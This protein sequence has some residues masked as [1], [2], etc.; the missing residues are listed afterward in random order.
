MIYR[1]HRGRRL[2]EIGVGCYGLSGA[3]GRKYPAE[4]QHLIQR[5]HEL[6][7]NYFDTAA[8][9]G[10]GERL[11]GTAVAPFRQQI[12]LTTKIDVGPEGQTSLSRRAVRQACARSLKRLQT[13]YLDLYLV[14]FDDP[15]TPVAETITAL[16]ELVQAGHIRH[17]GVSHL[18]QER[19]ADFLQSGNLLAVM[20]ELS[21][22]SYQSRDQ[23]LP[24]CRKHG[25]A[26]IAFSV[27]GR[28]LLTGRFQRTADFPAGDIRRLDPLFQRERLASG[29]RVAA[30]LATIG[31]Q[32][33]KTA[34]QVAIAWVLAQPGISCALTGP[35]TVT[36][37]E[38]NVGGSGW[39]LDTAL[40][41]DLEQFLAAEAVWLT[42]AQR[43]AVEQLLATPLPNDPQQA[44]VDLV[45]VTETAVL[46]ELVSEAAIM[47]IFQELFSRRQ[48]LA[49]AAPQ[50]A[51]L[52]GRL[53]Q[54][55]GLGERPLDN[56]K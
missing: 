17:Y 12:F 18:P 11:L 41:T 16:E 28:G 55:I 39:T 47:P 36:H 5:A 2:S 46:L 44:F 48:E 50:L 29:R 52:Q 22:V 31:Q 54:A 4:F 40:M 43:Q 8:A 19:I 21:A 33:G 13:D 26:G 25:A 37:L 15:Q 53:A 7:V 35:S 38:E 6:G 30:K 49:T 42:T 24:L 32:V 34:V 56:T 23:L 27:T 20:M 10:D 45:Y 3:Y 51:Q 9:Y 14:H 1:E